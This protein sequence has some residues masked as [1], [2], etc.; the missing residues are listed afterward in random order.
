VRFATGQ[1]IDGIRRTPVCGRVA[2]LWCNALLEDTAGGSVRSPPLDGL[3]QAVKVPKTGHSR[4]LAFSMCLSWER[5]RRGA[6]S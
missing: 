3:F 4:N 5:L 2:A 1:L 6:S